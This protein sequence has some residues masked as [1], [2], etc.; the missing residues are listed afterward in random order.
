MAMDIDFVIT[1]VDGNDVEW[2]KEKAKYESR[3]IGD[4]RDKRFREWGLLPYW[5]RAVEKYAPWV[6]Y[7]HFVTCGHLP[8]WLNVEN[9]KLRI[10][11]HTDFIDSEYLPTFSC[12]PIELNIHRIPELSE[13]FVYF[14]DDMFLTNDVTES[15]F[16]ENGL[17]CDTAILDAAFIDGGKIG[18]RKLDILEYNTS[19]VMNM[20]PLNRNFI[21]KDVISKN[22]NKWYSFK[23][24]PQ[25]LRNYLLKPWKNFTGIKSFH[26]PYSYF[27]STFED[28]WEKEPEI[29]KTACSHKF[30]NSMDISSRL[31]SYWQLASGT[32][33]PRS[34]KIGK[35]FYITGDAE[36]DERIFNAIRNKKY[37]T[38]CIN[39]EFE[40]DDF[41]EVQR[42]IICVFN[43]M[44]P[45]RSSFER[46]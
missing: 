9:P 38:I 13:T 11:K 17:P 46:Y 5:F 29:L 4:N 44:L 41:E 31:F 3:D 2:Q 1:W 40:G 10:A 20:V 7:V 19:P 8:S 35:M 6:R 21:K 45:Q 34:P 14:N 15:D 18:G 22:K 26:L 23:Y 37:K 25:M 27:K 12:R 28:V 39:D 36:N 43:E 32:F 24:G 16:F 30:R 42:K 33:S